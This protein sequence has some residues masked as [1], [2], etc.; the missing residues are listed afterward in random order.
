MKCKLLIAMFVAGVFAACSD[1]DKIGL[2]C[3]WMFRKRR[4]VSPRLPEVR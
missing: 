1:D 2:T 3:P 4:F